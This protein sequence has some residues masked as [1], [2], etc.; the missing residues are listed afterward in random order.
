[1]TYQDVLYELKDGVA[2]VTIN[3]P[4][5]MNAVTERTLDELIHA[6]EQADADPSTGVAVLTGAGDV[7]FCAG[8]DFTSMMK[9][10]RKNAHLWN[11]R[12][13]R[14]AMVIRGVR[15]PVI[16]RINGWCMGGGNEFNTF[17]DLAIAS[18]R[19]RFGQTGARVGACPVMG[20]TQYLPFF[21]GERKAKE[22]IFL[23]YT[24]TA[25]EALEMGLV[26]KVVPHEKLD[27]AAR[28]WCDRILSL[29]PTT[30]R[31]TKVSLNFGSD[32]MYGQWKHGSELLSYIWGS[33]ESLEGMNAFMEKRA[34]NFAPFR[35]R[36]W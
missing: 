28:E 27:E 11:N 6:F 7:A 4:E 22:M 5:K 21:I 32:L 10:N 35:R 9:L 19:A 34:P 33:E 8:G 18:D 24:Y 1:M 17:C 14:L 16:A 25:Q 2:T 29:A 20:A 23:C 31:A 13:I 12:M 30:L 36:G 3:R 26:N 15:V